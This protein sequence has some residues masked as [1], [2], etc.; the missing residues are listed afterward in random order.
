MRF[1]AYGFGQKS[2]RTNGREQYLRAPWLK[3]LL[4]RAEQ[5]SLMEDM[6]KDAAVDSPQGA[7]CHCRVLRCRASHVQQWMY[8]LTLFQILLNSAWSAYFTVLAPWVQ[9][10]I[11]QRMQGA[12]VECCCACTEKSAP[13]HLKTVDLE[14]RGSV[15]VASHMRTS[16][17]LSQCHSWS[18]N[19]AIQNSPTN[20]FLHSACASNVCM[21]LRDCM[22]EK[23][24]LRDCLGGRISVLTWAET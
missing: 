17:S 4:F 1:W 7:G 10:W 23:M 18:S 5:P 11:L 3:N 13:L 22:R 16:C 19:L 15:L 14:P 20:I 24:N 8:S 21:V 12:S 9:R 2:L 6:V